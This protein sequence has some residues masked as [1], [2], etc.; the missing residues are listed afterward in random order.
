MPIYNDIN[1]TPH[2]L[3]IPEAGRIYLNLGRNA[4]YEAAHRSDIPTMKIGR[5]LLVP[6]RAMERKLDEV[7]TPASE[8]GA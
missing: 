8:H 1:T 6:I 2:V 5:K 7:G 3:S 4:S